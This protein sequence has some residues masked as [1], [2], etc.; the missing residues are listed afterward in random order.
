LTVGSLNIAGL[1]GVN[2]TR[3]QKNSSTNS[4]VGFGLDRGR[5]GRGLGTHSPGRNRISFEPLLRRAR[6]AA[7]LWCRAPLR[8]RR[9]AVVARGC[10]VP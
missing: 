3:S 7:T 8:S 9:G 4:A 5:L 6:A 1:R 2:L 10:A